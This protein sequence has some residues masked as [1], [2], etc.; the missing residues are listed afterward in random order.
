MKLLNKSKA[1]T[2]SLFNL[3][4]GLVIRKQSEPIDIKDSEVDNVLLA[5][6]SNITD[7]GN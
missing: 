5:N 6:Y 7:K 1:M 2:N 4:V 3:A